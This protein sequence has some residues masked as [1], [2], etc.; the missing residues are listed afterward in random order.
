MSCV[1]WL[2]SVC[3]LVL[4]LDMMVIGADHSLVLLSLGYVTVDI[5]PG[6]FC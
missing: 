5:Q 2:V 3:F 4:L 1:G 6:I